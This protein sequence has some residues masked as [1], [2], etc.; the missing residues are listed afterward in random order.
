M[1]ERGCSRESSEREKVIGRPRWIAFSDERLDEVVADIEAGAEPRTSFYLMLIASSMIACLGLVANSTAVIIGAMLVSPLMTPIFGVALAMLKG[2]HR[3]FPKALFA[4]FAGVAF[5]VGSAYLFGLVWISAEATPA[6][7]A[8][9]DPHLLDLLVAVFAG[10]AGAYALL[11]ERTSPA[12]PGVA[13]ATA[14]VPPLSAAGLCLAN[15]AYR[16]AGGAL[17]LFFANFVAILLVALVTFS[18]AGI[19]PTLQWKSFSHLLR[20]YGFTLVS[21]VVVAVVLTHSLYRITRDRYVTSRVQ[22]ILSAEFAETGSAVLDD[23]NHRVV[24]GKLQLLATVR[25]PRLIPPDRVQE[26]EKD[27]GRQLGMPAT[28]IVRTVLANDVSATGSAIHA[29]GVDLDGVFLSKGLSGPQLKT[30]YAEQALLE[31]LQHEPAVELIGVEC[32]RVEDRSLVLATVQSIRVLSRQEISRLEAAVRVRLQDPELELVVQ[33]VPTLLS[34]RLGPILIGWTNIDAATPDE[35]EG[36]AELDGRIRA[37]IA[38]LTDV[39]P[40]AVHFNLREEAWGVLVETTGPRAVAPKEVTAVQ[41]TFSKHEPPLEINLWHK[42]EAVVTA[43]G[44]MDYRNFTKST[45][46]ERIKTLPIIFQETKSEQEP[47]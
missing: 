36:L 15:G 14:V 43:D 21:F 29:T 11:D 35:A 13:I 26:I 17:L 2:D 40:V 47:H 42:P 19:A 33:F 5:A 18:V 23:F 16:G 1:P 7:L 25:A 38:R 8:R 3:L 12:L 4:E 28:L 27:L 44:Y 9:T 37:E 10:F 41:A 34:D 24:G 45:L 22:D 39:F 30:R 46:Q 31:Q 6:M 32:G 20:R